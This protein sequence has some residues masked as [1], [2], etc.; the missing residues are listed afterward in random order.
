MSSADPTGTSLNG[1]TIFRRI[2]FFTILV[3]LSLYY[4]MVHFRGLSEPRA[5]EQASIGRELARH[6]G[7]KS[8]TLR[9]VAIWQSERAAGEKTTLAQASRCLLY[10]SPSPRDS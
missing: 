3:S 10:T 1:A 9:P 5:M 4:L 2:L 6:N 7:F 8:K